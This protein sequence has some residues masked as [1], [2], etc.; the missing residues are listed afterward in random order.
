M[1][2]GIQAFDKEALDEVF[3]RPAIREVAFEIRF[4]PRLR[5]NAELWRIQDAIVNEYPIVGTEGM[6]QPNGA[7]VT[8]NVFQNPATG[9]ALKISQE[10]FVVVFSKYTR[11]EDFK[12]EAIT[13]VR[14]FCETFEVSSFSRVGLR[15]VN[16]IITPPSD[17]S[18]ILL[19]YVRPV[20]DFERISA[21]SIDQFVTEIRLRQN[22][23]L[24][25]LRGAL[26]SELEDHRRIYVLDIDC[27]TGMQQEARDL[28]ALLDRFHETAQIFFLD[29]ITEQYKDV[30]RGRT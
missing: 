22:D 21:S 24:V 18:G 7:V 19:R 29:H 25:T 10:N 28:D 17:S 5:V 1:T 9:R 3:A 20:V 4:A 14:A 13:R 26:L 8:I 11:F 6:V 12:S 15:Y 30:M 23:H 2:V 16:N 27:H